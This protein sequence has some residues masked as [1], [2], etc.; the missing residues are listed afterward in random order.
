MKVLVENNLYIEGD[1]QNVE[2]RKYTGKKDAK[3]G[4]DLYTTY[5]YYATVEQAAEKVV[6]MKLAESQATNL[7]EL[8]EDIKSIKQWLKEKL[9]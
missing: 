7:K 8:S 5:G 1:H 4:K 3:T 2:V 9:S 6:R